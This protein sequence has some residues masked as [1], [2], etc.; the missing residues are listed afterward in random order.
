MKSD[1]AAI[2][3]RAR[4]AGLV[5]P[6][7]NIPYLPMMAPVVRAVR[8]ADSF[9]FIAVARLEWIKFEAGGPA[10]VKD[11][12]DRCGD[13]RHTRLHLDHVPVVDEDGFRVDFMTLIRNALDLGYHSVM[14]DGSRLPLDENIECTRRAVAA[15]HAAGVPCEA[16]LGAVLGHEEGP[17]PPY[18]ELFRSGHGFTDIE[19]ARRFVQETR[20]DWLS[21]AAGNIHGAVSPAARDRAKTAARLNLEHIEKLSEAAG[22]PLVLHG[23][24]G[25]PR[26]YVLGGIRRGIAK[27][28]IGTDIR[29]AYER[30]LRQ[31]G[32]VETARDAVYQKVTNILIN[33]LELRGVR[34][35]LNP[36]E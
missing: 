31:T 20:C 15:A 29:Q 16:E 7:F 1:S 8:D 27:I 25:I 17:L 3:R 23:G 32:D 5:V 24:S 34:S 4:D 36:D 2:V 10:A 30:A 22:V 14:V 12:F 28:N 11:E 33:V 6:A 21:I 19:E 9:A 26:E 13:L 35:V 18:E